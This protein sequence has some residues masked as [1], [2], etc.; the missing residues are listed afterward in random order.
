MRRL[1]Y[2]A[3]FLLYAARVAAQTPVPE[4][5]DIIASV[6]TLSGSG[7]GH[8]RIL[9]YTPDGTLKGELTSSPQLFEYRE[10]LVRDGIVYVGRN[11]EI[12][13]YSLAGLPLSRFSPLRA[14]FLAPALDGGLVGSNVSGQVF[15]LNADGAIRFYRDTITSFEPPAQGVELAS[16]QCTVFYHSAGALARWDSCMN[17][18]PMF[19]GPVRSVPGGRGLRLLPDSSFL[20]ATISDVAHLDRNGKV[21]R[22]YGV[23][24]RAVAL[25]LDGTSF[26]TGSGSLLQ[27][28]DI[29]S[30][31][32]LLRVN[33]GEGIEY[34]SVVGERRASLL[35]AVDGSIPALSVEWLIFLSLALVLIGWRAVR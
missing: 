33:I 8:S 9:I 20:A 11:T 18:R 6:T 4:E 10:T 22:S 24:G 21:I 30:G 27:K 25:D 1:V 31:A 2:F 7:G 35:A 29:S 23:T 14:N 5:G 19:F 16:D 12:S 3:F 26:W 17:T 15:R 13:R 34:L 28:I 32:V